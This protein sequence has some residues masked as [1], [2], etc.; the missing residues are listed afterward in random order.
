M[1]MWI[2]YKATKQSVCTLKILP[3]SLKTYVPNTYLF[4]V[5]VLNRK[6]FS[7]FEALSWHR[8]E[9]YCKW[10]NTFSWH[11]K[12]PQSFCSPLRISQHFSTTGKIM[13]CR[14][15]AVW[16]TPDQ[17]S[18]FKSVLSE[19]PQL[20]LTLK[21]KVSSSQTDNWKHLGSKYSNLM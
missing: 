17:T 9:T 1:T 21:I 4:V 7:F 10:Q 2:V 11:W 8:T 13:G 20:S 16:I 5:E 6:L 3:Q 15:G 19:N 12:Y 14:A 18:L